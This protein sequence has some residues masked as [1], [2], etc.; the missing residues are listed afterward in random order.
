[1][2]PKSVVSLVLLT[3]A[4][5][6]STEALAA[7]PK[8]GPHDDS[9]QASPEKASPAKKPET[10]RLRAT[11]MHHHKKHTH[12]KIVLVAKPKKDVA[13]AAVAT[14]PRPR[15]ALPDHG[16]NAPAGYEP[17]VMMS[18]PLPMLPS[19]VTHA[20]RPQKD[21]DAPLHEPKLVDAKPS[22][23]VDVKVDVKVDSKDVA[24]DTKGEKAG[25]SVVKADARPEPKL[26]GKPAKG[27][28]KADPAPRTPLT[29]HGKGAKLV[30]PAC[31]HEAVEVSRGT[32]E[33]KFSLTRCDGSVAPLAAE[34]LSVLLRPGNVTR[35]V[36]IT[37]TTPGI[38][39][40]DDKLVERLQTM[41]EHFSKPKET[42]KVT[43]ISGYRPS[44]AGSYHASGRAVD[45]RIEGVPNMALVAFCKTIPDTGC[46]F[47]PNSSF[48]HL[49]VRDPGVGHVTWIDAS[50]SGESPRYVSTWP[51]PPVPAKHK[52]ADASLS[53]LDKDV[54]AVVDEHPAQVTKEKDDDAPSASLQ[55][56][57]P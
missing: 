41:V 2:L 7:S 32:E 11:R 19:P 43:V 14:T 30:K 57:T 38:L 53:K 6:A 4:L 50:G 48:V 46:G 54:P 8:D 23:K 15:H 28:V 31:M 56:E 10:T 51:P 42:A 36:Q 21:V 3:L 35:P 9:A 55:V 52:S 45:F 24:A 33:E 26:D 37:S 29:I 44:A 16:A 27:D 13:P 47:Y 49:D 25:K 39:R 18:R 1:M 40:V 5:P 20:A 34:K 17:V 12:Q 22:S